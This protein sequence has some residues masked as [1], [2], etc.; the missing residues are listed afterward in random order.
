MRQDDAKMA[1][2]LDQEEFDLR[3]NDATVPLAMRL[4]K[5]ENAELNAQLAKMIGTKDERKDEKLDLQ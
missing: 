2:V 1:M 4:F 3:K 5:P